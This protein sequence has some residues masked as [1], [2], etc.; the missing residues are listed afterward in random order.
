MLSRRR[1]RSFL[2]AFRTQPLLWLLGIAPSGAAAIAL[3]P[4]SFTLQQFNY[5]HITTT[6][7]T[8][9][10]STNGVLHTICVN[11]VAATGTI[12]VYDNTSAATPIIAVISAGT[13]G[14]VQ[15]DVVFNTGLT[16]VT[17]TAAGDLTVSW[18]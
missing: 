12:T 18:L 16:I 7:T 10:K 2:D 9:L 14:C 17:A 11:T 13:F 15:Y 5:S 3:G 4:P 6:T 1:F 8:T